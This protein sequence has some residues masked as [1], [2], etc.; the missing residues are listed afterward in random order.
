[1]KYM[2]VTTTRFVYNRRLYTT[3]D[4]VARAQQLPEVCRTGSYLECVC[5]DFETRQM[6]LAHE[7]ARVDPE[8]FVEKYNEQV[9]EVN[10]VNEV[11]SLVSA[12]VAAA[13]EDAGLEAVDE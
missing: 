8:A 2:A 1:M 5:E 6:I 12:A 3:Q 4:V 13:G 11:V 7:R 10:E 9:N